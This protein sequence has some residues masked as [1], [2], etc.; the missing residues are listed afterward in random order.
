MW[1]QVEE[2]IHSF[3]HKLFSEGPLHFRECVQKSSDVS[4]QELI[5]K[6]SD[7]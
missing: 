1:S 6:S 5:Q 4:L 3:I 2:F 7:L